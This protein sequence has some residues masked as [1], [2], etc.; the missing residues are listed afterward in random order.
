M[1]YAQV[2]DGIVVNV[3]VWEGT[4]PLGLDGELINVDD[5]PCGPGWLYTDG[6]FVA[7]SC[8]SVVPVLG[9]EQDGE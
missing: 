3:I 6:V 9:V 5:I 1:N 8:D 4:T 2:I 7:P